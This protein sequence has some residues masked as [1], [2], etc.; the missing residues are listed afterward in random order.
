MDQFRAQMNLI[1]I[2]QVSRIIFVLKTHFYIVFL[3]FIDLWIGRQILESA[4]ALA[5]MLL[6]LRE[7]PEWTASLFMKSVGSL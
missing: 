7:T 1:W 2:I 6:W 5:Q 4:G 3:N